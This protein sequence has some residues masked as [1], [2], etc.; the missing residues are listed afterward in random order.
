MKLFL[1]TS[2][3]RKILTTTYLKFCKAVPLKQLYLPFFEKA[4]KGNQTVLSTSNYR[5]ILLLQLNLNFCK[6]NKNKKYK[7][8]CYRYDSTIKQFGHHQSIQ[9]NAPIQVEFAV[10]PSQELV[11]FSLTESSSKPLVVYE[12]SGISG[13]SRKIVASGITQSVSMRHFTTAD[14]QHF[15]VLRLINGAIAV[16][17]AVF[18]GQLYEE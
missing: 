17:K 4:W 12:Y 7:K 15:V 3:K 8:F 10:L 5:E 16:F 1:S 9:L 6:L 14:Q 2:N 18:K 13:F 11:L